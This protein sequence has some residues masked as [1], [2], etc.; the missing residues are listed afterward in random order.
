[1]NIKG[2]YEFAAKNRP[3]GWNVWLTLVILLT[4]SKK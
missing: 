2:F 1:V 4:P 3:D